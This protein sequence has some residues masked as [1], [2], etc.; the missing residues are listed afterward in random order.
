MLLR[1]LP[2]LPRPTFVCLP[3]E[4]QMLCPATVSSQPPSPAP[5]KS[6]ST[7][8]RQVGSSF[9]NRTHLIPSPLPLL[10]LPSPALASLGCLTKLQH[11]LRPLPPS[12]HLSPT[13]SPAP[14]AAPALT[15]IHFQCRRGGQRAMA[16]DVCARSLSPLSASPM[17]AGRLGP[18]NLRIPCHGR[19]NCKSPS[20]N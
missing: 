7:P 14:T 1:T 19:K 6:L 4:L 10:A 8:A 5:P 3:N 9:S 16:A 11:S 18:W 2:Q 20:S 15:V 17:K 12:A 13:S